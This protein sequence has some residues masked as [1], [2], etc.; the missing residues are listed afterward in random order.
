AP[1]TA[2]LPYTTLFR[3]GAQRHHLRAGERRGVDQVVGLVLAGA[4][5][6]V[7]EDQAALGVGVEDLDGRA[8]VL[9]EDV[10]RAL[11]GTRR[12]V[13]GRSEEHTSELQSRENL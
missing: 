13:L 6:R 7:G 12:H 11:R 9:G 4:D 5:D 3:S 2:L 1:G 8:A 10:A